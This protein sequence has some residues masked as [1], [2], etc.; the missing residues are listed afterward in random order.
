MRRN[1]NF[2]SIGLA[3][4]LTWGATTA[5]AAPLGLPPLSFPG[6]AAAGFTGKTPE[7]L[8][9]PSTLDVP[10]GGPKETFPG[11]GSKLEFPGQGLTSGIGNLPPWLPTAP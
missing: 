5:M 10:Q 2:K 9:P 4:V 8:F 11:Q 6:Q 3:L 7:G 1:T